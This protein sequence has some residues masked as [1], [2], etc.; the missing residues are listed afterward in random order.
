[1]GKNPY[2]EASPMVSTI[3]LCPP[4]SGKKRLSERGQE[5]NTTSQQRSCQWASST[6][7]EVHE[8]RN[9]NEQDRNEKQKRAHFTV[10]GIFGTNNET[11][12]VDMPGV[13]QGW[14]DASRHP[15][16]DVSITSGSA[17]SSSSVRSRAP[18]LGP[19]PRNRM[20]L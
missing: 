15:L 8:R 5:D 17:F 2:L 13:F 9:Q 18:S 4:V 12:Y 16:S 7:K 1:M 10:A 3:V 19:L 11:F 14:M 20:N 6:T